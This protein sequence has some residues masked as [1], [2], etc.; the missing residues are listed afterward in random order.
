MPNQISH[1]PTSPTAMQLACISVLDG[2]TVDDSRC[3]EWI[4]ASAISAV[5]PADGSFSAH[6][7]ASAK[8]DGATRRPRPP[9][10]LVIVRPARAEWP[11]QAG[12]FV[13]L[14]TL[15][16]PQRLSILAERWRNWRQIWPLR[17]CVSV[18]QLPAAG[19]TTAAVE[20]RPH[21]SCP[22][23]VLI[24]A[25]TRLSRTFSHRKSP[26]WGIR[27]IQTAACPSSRAI[28]PDRS[29]VCAVP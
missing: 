29:T 21:A 22:S 27:P 10:R 2:H 20:H 8:M 7:T 11:S 23:R 24:M 16:S 18:A 13:R 17:N 4:S 1:S 9:R 28:I 25:T 26:W 5:F 12:Q 15:A 14:S 6:G 3:V 19:T